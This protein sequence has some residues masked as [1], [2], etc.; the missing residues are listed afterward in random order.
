M[1]VNGISVSKASGINFPFIQ[2]LWDGVGISNGYYCDPPSE[3]FTQRF[4]TTDT[5]YFQV[6]LD[7]FA[8]TYVSI[9]AD[10]YPA[11]QV[12]T[13]NNIFSFQIPLSGY[14][15]STIVIN[16]HAQGITNPGVDILGQ[17]LPIEVIQPIEDCPLAL[18]E[19]RNSCP[20]MGIDYSLDP[21]FY[22]RMRVPLMRIRPSN[23]DQTEI[24]LTKSSSGLWEFCSSDLDEVYIFTTAP[25]PD[26][27]HQII[28]KAL[29]H[30]EFLVNGAQFIQKN[31]FRKILQDNALYLGEAELIPVN[32][33]YKVDLCCDQGATF[34][35]PPSAALACDTPAAAADHFAID[36]RASR[37]G[38]GMLITAATP[39]VRYVYNFSSIYFAE[40][41][42]GTDPT[43][44]ANWSFLAGS[45]TAAEFETNIVNNISLPPGGFAGY[46]EVAEAAL[47]ALGLSLLN[48]SATIFENNISG[49]SGTCIVTTASGDPECP[50]PS[51]SSSDFSGLPL[52][53]ISNEGSLDNENPAN[54][55]NGDPNYT[56]THTWFSEPCPAFPPLGFQLFTVSGVGGSSTLNFTNWHPSILAAG[57]PVIEALFSGGMGGTG[58]TVDKQQLVQTLIGSGL[59]P[60]GGN[61]CVKS[62][63][64]HNPTSCQGTTE[65]NV[66]GAVAL[67]NH[68]AIFLGTTPLG[69]TNT[70]IGIASYANQN[71]QFGSGDI[72]P[73]IANSDFWL[74]GDIAL[75][76]AVG[77]QTTL[78]TD[79]VTLQLTGVGYTAALNTNVFVAMKIRD[80]QGI[81][82]YTSF[83]SRWDN[84]TD[85]NYVRPR[86]AAFP[87]AGLT[88]G[89]TDL[90]L[91]PS[92][93]AGG[94]GFLAGETLQG[95]T[96]EL[97]RY[98]LSTD[99]DI[100]MTGNEDP[101]AAGAS[102]LVASLD[103]A[104]TVV[105]TTNPSGIQI[106]HAAPQNGIYMCKWVLTTTSGLTIEHIQSATVINY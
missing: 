96:T 105:A 20:A 34:S 52:V 51:L 18:L 106:V 47:T 56:F 99:P 92:Y 58:Y 43:N 12:D 39:N 24:K 71:G 53:R 36:T 40:I 32:Q 65:I 23:A 100:I 5:L 30:E 55:I 16:I 27:M 46:F 48:V 2:S 17:S 63:V 89:G 29:Q 81:R 87:V 91:R 44:I 1:A 8:L 41:S 11:Y 7:T 37:D 93:D 69:D 49:G 66:P 33:P 42:N 50:I 60:P 14:P 25:I 104:G 88:N 101:E 10:Q 75:Q 94:T 79:T 15:D 70:T 19:W 21:A 74:E 95:F 84:A 28:R 72:G 31:P 3:S 64:T 45:G 6:K 35:I 62:T 77:N 98:A 85:S 57:Q 61:W 86:W 9:N 26:F 90:L 83:Y 73:E 102:P 13:V 68:A 4:Y 76:S 80:N 97:R 67:L 78:D 59:T 103:P 38:T 82:C 54:L 22:N